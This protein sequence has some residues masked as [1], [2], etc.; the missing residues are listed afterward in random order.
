MDTDRLPLLNSVDQLRWNW[1][2]LINGDGMH[3]LMHQSHQTCTDASVPSDMHW[4]ISPIRHA[5]IHQSHQTCTDSS[6]PSDMH[7][8]IS[9][10]RH[11]LIL[12]CIWRHLYTTFNDINTKCY[13]NSYK[14]MLQLNYS[15]GHRPK[16]IQFP[17]ESNRSIK[18]TQSTI[19]IK[20]NTK[21]SNKM[22][23]RHITE[24]VTFAVA[25]V[26]KTS[27]FLRSYWSCFTKWNLS[28]WLGKIK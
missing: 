21:L 5:L 22:E 27:V 3:A 13:L 6:V 2:R 1:L 4:C 28:A 18:C 8:C 25:S 19:S 26:W 12:N 24:T 11:A 20:G 10:I 9:P 15:V 17:Y 23:I 14:T 16:G 7:W